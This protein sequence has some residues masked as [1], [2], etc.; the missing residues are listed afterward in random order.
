MSEAAPALKFEPRWE[1]IAARAPQL[2]ATM[3]QY[4]EQM[5]LSLRPASIAAFELTLRG[6]AGFVIDRDRRLRR[7]RHVRREHIEAY[8]KWLSGRPVGKAKTISARTVRHRLGILR[9]C[10][11]R[12]IEWG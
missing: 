10:F 7:L 1:P 5:S 6:F 9:V 3:A 2:A 8:K 11:E 4:L 12:V